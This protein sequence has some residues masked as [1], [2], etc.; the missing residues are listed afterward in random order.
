MDTDEIKRRVGAR[1]DQ[2]AGFAAQ[3]GD[4]L[5]AGVWE[6]VTQLIAEAIGYVIGKASDFWE[7][8]KEQ[9]A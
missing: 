2:D 5:E 8:L 6:I 4:A 7:W 9:F 3:L 1:I